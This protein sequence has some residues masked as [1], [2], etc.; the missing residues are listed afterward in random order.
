MALFLFEN[1]TETEAMPS[2]KK[3]RSGYSVYVVELS[4]KVWSERLRFRQANSHYGGL[5]ECLYV[6]MTSHTPK[7]RFLKHKTG[8]RNKKGYKISSSYVEK[9]GLYLRPSLYQEY[10]PLTREEA[11]KM[12]EKL[13]LELRK[14]GYA[15]WWN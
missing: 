8:H 13:A 15:V 6:G 12:E 11:Y 4:K 5:K 3:S 10:N 9:Y 7:E 14:R 2:A 1:K